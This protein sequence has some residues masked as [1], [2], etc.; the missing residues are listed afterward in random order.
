MIGHPPQSDAWHRLTRLLVILMLFC[1][2]GATCNRNFR[3]P[4][5]TMGP[6]APEVLPLNPTLDQVIAAVNQN[7]AKV[8]NYQTN[9]AT[10]SVPGN[11]MVPALRGNIA[12]ELPNKLRLQASTALSGPEVDLGSNAE[13]FWF[14]VKRNEPP[15][16]YFSRHDQFTGSAAQQVIPIEPSWLLDALGFMQ[17]A[18][19]DFHEGP[20]SHGN[21]TLEIRSV[22]QSRLG[23]LTRNTVIDARRA[24]V[25]QQH[26][27][28]GQGTRLATAVARSNQYY[29]ALGVS[30]PQEIEVSLP[31]A[32][33]DL[34]I[35]VGTVQ[36]NQM[37]PN[38]AL[39]QLPVLTG[40]PQIDLGTAPANT[41]SAMGAPGS[42]DW[43]TGAS[44][45][46]L[47]I[48]P[49]AGALA[50]SSQERPIASYV[51]PPVTQTSA[52]TVST[53]VPPHTAPLAPQSQFQRLPVGGVP[54]ER[55]SH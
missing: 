6:P 7:A 11:A 37:A 40:Y 10:I 38:P 1:C 31:L 51:M 39:W 27:Y 20:I 43:N 9:N 3:S 35:D 49:P 48:D 46:W 28:D 45:S 44:P 34:H 54:L 21:G 15:A 12:A 5:S 24:W 14:W 8:Q 18:P 32:Q 30:L 25:L 47:G 16:L 2:S 29:P 13:L 55:N 26:I 22:V 19:T 33:M 41:V 4:F 17:F 36:I 53:P 23:P 52:T 42:T 50:T